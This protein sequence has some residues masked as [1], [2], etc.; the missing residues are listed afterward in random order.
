M[1]AQC[2]GHWL[3]QGKG[4]GAAGVVAQGPGHEA[5]AVG[6]VIIPGTHLVL[7]CLYHPCFFSSK[8]FKDDLAFFSPLLFPP[9]H[10]G[11]ALSKV[12]QKR[13]D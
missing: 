8:S 5:S 1:V 13:F 10:F 7:A 12:G 4:C 9:H 3:P 2:L 11:F 6:G